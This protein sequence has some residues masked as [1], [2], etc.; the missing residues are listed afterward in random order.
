MPPN[1]TWFTGRQAVHGFL[2]NR[3]LR[4]DFFHLVPANANGQP[5]A[6]TYER[7]TDGRLV[8]HAFRS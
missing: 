7:A 6:V 4:R 5:A 1:P 3:V 2:A 8:P